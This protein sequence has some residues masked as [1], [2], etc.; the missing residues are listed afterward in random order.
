MKK[1]TALY[2]F[3]NS[4]RAPGSAGVQVEAL[5]NWCHA[6]GI[7]NYRYFADHES[8]TTNNGEEMNVRAALNRMLS[9]VKKQKVSQVICFETEQIGDSPSEK[10][11]VLETCNNHSTPVIAVSDAKIFDEVGPEILPPPIVVQE[12]ES[13]LAQAENSDSAEVSVENESER[14]PPKKATGKKRGRK[15][16]RNVNLINQLLDAG[17]SLS[18]IAKTAGCSRATVQLQKKLWRAEKEAVAVEIE[19][20]LRVPDGP[21][22]SCSTEGP[23]HFAQAGTNSDA[24]R[25]FATDKKRMSLKSALTMGTRIYA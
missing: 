9:K 20:P 15:L 24:N 25:N 12:H 5:A 10:N 13:I 7:T 22:A 23:G 2:I 6:K 16:T 14:S 8:E 4:T 18:R 1:F 11:L 19:P 21:P 17:E 3:I